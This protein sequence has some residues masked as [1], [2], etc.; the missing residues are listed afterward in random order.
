M[1][2]DIR[3]IFLIVIILII[4]AVVVTIITNT[5]FNN[6]VYDNTS[7]NVDDIFYTV[8]YRVSGLADDVDVRYRNMLGGTNQISNVGLPWSHTQEYRMKGDYLSI[9]ASN[10]GDWGY[11]KTEIYLDGVLVK[12][13]IDDY[14]ASCSGYI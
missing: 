8:K 2:K 6:N 14:Y 4:A 1:Q 12:Y 11:V 9:S 7:F 3:K 10:G 13:S 5:Y